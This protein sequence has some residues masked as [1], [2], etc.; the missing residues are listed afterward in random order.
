MQRD[1]DLNNS[2]PDTYKARFS[3]EPEKAE[4]AERALRWF[5][6]R[7]SK[8]YIQFTDYLI[9][10][11]KENEKKL[12]LTNFKTQKQKWRSIPDKNME[13]YDNLPEE[14]SSASFYRKLQEM[15]RENPDETTESLVQKIKD[16]S[17]SVY[18]VKDNSPDPDLKIEDLR[19]PVDGIWRLAKKNKIFCLFKKS[20]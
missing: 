8:W 19:E 15:K 18:P 16:G 2:D 9:N 11:A 3:S 5:D 12:Y 20:K 10:F 13:V 1:A 17:I 6:K 4:M 14:L 7:T